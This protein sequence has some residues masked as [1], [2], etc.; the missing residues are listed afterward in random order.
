[1]LFIDTRKGET[2]SAIEAVLKGTSSNGG[3]FLPQNLPKLTSADFEFL[4]EL[5]FNERFAYIASLFFEEF[6]QESILEAV[7]SIHAENDYSLLEIDDGLHFLELWNNTCSY[8]DTCLPFLRAIYDLYLKKKETKGKKLFISTKPEQ[9]PALANSFK[10]AEYAIV[11]APFSANDCS[12]IQELSSFLIKAD[13]VYPFKINASRSTIYDT[14]LSVIDE[15]KLTDTDIENVVFPS[16]HWVCIL[17]LICCFISAY[18]DLLNEKGK[19]FKSF[20]VSIPE[21]DYRC[22]IA[23]YYAKEMGVPIYSIIAANGI[24][25]PLVDFLSNGIYKCH[26]E[27][28]D[29]SALNEEYPLWEIL[30][31][32]LCDRDYELA[33][34]LYKSYEQTN[35]FALKRSFYKKGLFA[36]DCSIDDTMTCTSVILDEYDYL[37]DPS[38]ASAYSVYNDYYAES[39]DE[40]DSIIVSL[41]NPFRFPIEVYSAITGKQSKNEIK[42]IL[43]LSFWTGETIPDF[44]VEIDPKTKEIPS[45]SV[46]DLKKKVQIIIKDALK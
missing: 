30:T 2:V 36:G 32:E 46:D 26:N 41:Y 43:D 33:R 9:I 28:N 22:L 39:G 29:I 7:E 6:S 18:C 17:P 40:R 20:N 4:K 37:A 19:K 44:L 45:L 8:D 35:E 11:L 21:G 15:L 42:T 3:F 10:D 27:K 13:N 23:S 16:S 38:L 31:F 24:N 25:G 12:R 34:E 1:M 5:S 14:V